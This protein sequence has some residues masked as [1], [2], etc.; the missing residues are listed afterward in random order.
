MGPQNQ[1]ARRADFEPF[2]D[3]H[4]IVDEIIGFFD[5]GLERQHNAV[6]D[7]AIHAFAKNPRRDQ[8]QYRFLAADDKGMTCIVTALETRNR[9]RL[10]SQ[11]INNLALALI[12]PLSSNDNYIPAHQ[13]LT[14]RNL[15]HNK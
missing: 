2:V 15:T 12:T 5:Q 4:T 7:Q 6:A 9:C 13:S 1:R 11:Q 8:V 10:L 3:R 14:R